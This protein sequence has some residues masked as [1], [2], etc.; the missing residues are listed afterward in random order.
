VPTAVYDA[1]PD[2]G[3]DLRFFIVRL[4]LPPQGLRG[5]G[6]VRA[7]IAYDSDGALIERVLQ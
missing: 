7:I 5:E 2:L 3:A 1:P 6:P 4:P